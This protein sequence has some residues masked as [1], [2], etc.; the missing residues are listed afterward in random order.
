MIMLIWLLK[1]LPKVAK[2]AT[3]LNLLQYPS[4]TQINKKTLYLSTFSGHVHGIWY[5]L[6]DYILMCVFVYVCLC[7][8]IYLF[9]LYILYIYAY[10]IYLFSQQGAKIKRSYRVKHFKPSSSPKSKR[11]ALRV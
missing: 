7:V 4:R 5:R 8:K 3:K 1:K 10:I 11:Y 2:L 9:M 6:L